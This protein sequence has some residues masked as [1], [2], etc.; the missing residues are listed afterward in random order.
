[1][2]NFV[3]SCFDIQC[4]VKNKT[5]QLSKKLVL[6]RVVEARGT[7]SNFLEDLKI[8]FKAKSSPWL[9]MNLPIFIPQTSFSSRE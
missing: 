3:I 1:M 2:F 8:F 9:Q 5:G 6:S 4:G 7:M